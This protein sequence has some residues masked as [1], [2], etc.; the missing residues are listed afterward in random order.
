MRRFYF[1]IFFAILL[2]VSPF[3]GLSWADAELPVSEGV[4][5][6]SSEAYVINFDFFKDRRIIDFEN[7]YARTLEALLDNIQNEPDPFE[8]E[9]FQKKIG[10]VK[11]QRE[12]ELKELQNIK[13]GMPN[14]EV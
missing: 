11:I 1:F 7:E 14:V 2:M 12:I 6:D 13:Q 9:K 3:A 4:I 10:D 5:T 8:R